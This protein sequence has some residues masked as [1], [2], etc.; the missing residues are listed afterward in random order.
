MVYGLAGSLTR[1]IFFPLKRQGRSQDVPT[2]PLC[3][4]SSRTISLKDIYWAPKGNHMLTCGFTLPRGYSRV[5]FQL[6]VPSWRRPRYCTRSQG[7]WIQGEKK[8]VK[9]NLLVG[10]DSI[11]WAKGSFL[12]CFGV[13]SKTYF[14][15][16][17]QNCSWVEPSSAFSFGWKIL[18]RSG[19][20]CFIVLYL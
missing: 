7:C 15:W 2:N 19:E 12:H 3:G 20:S 9:L 6:C 13:V 8:I 4:H 17:S 5:K 1:G 16:K 10:R 18:P 11:G 14:I